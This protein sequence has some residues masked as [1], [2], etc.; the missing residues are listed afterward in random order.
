[1]AQFRSAL[2][3]N[4]SCSSQQY[5]FTNAMRR[6]QARRESL[7]QK[8]WE[9]AKRQGNDA[10]RIVIPKRRIKR[11][12]VRDHDQQSQQKPVEAAAA[13]SQINTT[14]KTTQSN[15][16]IKHLC[17]S[18]NNS[19]EVNLSNI[20]INQKSCSLLP[21]PPLSNEKPFRAPIVAEP[22]QHLQKVSSQF[23]ISRVY[24]IKFN[25][26]K[27]Q[28]KKSVV[29]ENST[30]T[31]NTFSFHSSDDKLLRIEPIFEGLDAPITIKDGSLNA[32]LNQG[33]KIRL[34]L[35]FKHAQE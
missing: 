8:A 4:R 12:I 34:G 22:T 2:V 32:T 3:K 9:L 35:I 24:D 28:T 33:Q 20:R 21:N 19:G 11:V 1:M 25:K 18:L 10:I 5:P 6:Q 14:F 30:D 13:F 16:N 27:P 15:V 31:R 29:F 23:L 17:E 26:E 7:K